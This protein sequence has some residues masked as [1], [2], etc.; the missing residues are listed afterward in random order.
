M[1]RRISV[2]IVAA[3]LAPGVTLSACSR[4]EG[5]AVGPSGAQK[6][7]SWVRP[8]MIDGV[9]RDGAVLVVRG[10]ADPNARVVLRAPD[11]AAVAVNADGAGRFELRLPPLH[12][13]VRLTPEVQVGEDAAVSPETLVVIQ[14]GAGPVALI[15]AGQP[16]LR[17]D[18]SGVLNAVDSDGSTLIASGPAGSKPPVVMIGGVQANVVQ[19]ARGQ[20]RAM[21]GR[22]GAVGVAVDGQSFA[23][24]GDADGGGFSIARAGQGWRIIWPVAPGG[25]QSAWLPD[26]VAR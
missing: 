6:A 12:G 5:G 17:L 15:A 22:S 7:S 3:L 13:D 9:T 21:V 23:Y 8:P 4:G 1:K 24:P 14:G 25:H 19:A 11:V 20:W 10:A 26:R 16:T 18:G 2:T